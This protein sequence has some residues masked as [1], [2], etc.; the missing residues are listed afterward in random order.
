MS[1]LIM[2]FTIF[3]SELGDKS[4]IANILFASDA[5][6]NPWLVFMI[7]SIALVIATGLSVLA[8]SLAKEYLHIVPLKLVAGCGFIFIGCWT[9]YEHYHHTAA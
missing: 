2:F 7:A 8:G 4:Q 9:I 1:Y 6:N 3:F 5:K